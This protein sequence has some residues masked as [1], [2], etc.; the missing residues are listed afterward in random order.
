MNEVFLFQRADGSVVEVRAAS[1]MAAQ[2][3]AGKDAGLIASG[4]D[5]VAFEF[6]DEENL[7]IDLDGG[8]SAINE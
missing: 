6:E 3:I 5:E 2:E 4:H 8:L 1:Y 7:E